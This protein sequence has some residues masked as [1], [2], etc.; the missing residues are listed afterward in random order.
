MGN[1]SPERAGSSRSANGRACF[2][3]HGSLRFIFSKRRCHAENQESLVRRGLDRDLDGR[4]DLVPSKRNVY[5][6]GNGRHIHRVAGHGRDYRSPALSASPAQPQTG[7]PRGYA[8]CGTESQRSVSLRL[9]QEIQA[10]LWYLRLEATR[11][12]PRINGSSL[13]T[14]FQ[15]R[16]SPSAWRDPSAIHVERDIRGTS[17]PVDAFLRRYG[18]WQSLSGIASNR[19]APE[20]AAAPL[21]PMMPEGFPEVHIP[22]G[23]DMYRVGSN[24]RDSP[25]LVDGLRTGGHSRTTANGILCGMSSVSGK[26]A[27]SCT[28][29]FQ[30]RNPP[31]SR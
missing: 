25:D 7:A 3:P 14:C 9:G 15:C 28:T 11:L 27:V 20:R 29:S 13:D 4:V 1:G 8:A 5:H 26:I 24:R 12:R 23:E 31:T 22:G 10:L 2:E 17:W 16:K 6:S 30:R 19:A 21:P 18:R